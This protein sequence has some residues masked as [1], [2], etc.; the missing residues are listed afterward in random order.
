MKTKQAYVFFWSG[1]FKII[2]YPQQTE[3]CQSNSFQRATRKARNLGFNIKVFCGDRDPSKEDIKLR[4]KF[5][6]RRKYLMST[7]HYILPATR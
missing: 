1:I 7:G 6:V 4:K 2:T 5:G 3:I